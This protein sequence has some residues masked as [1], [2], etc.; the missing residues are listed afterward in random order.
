LLYE[1]KQLTECVQDKLS[2]LVWRGEIHRSLQQCPEEA[3]EKRESR[4]QSEMEDHCSR[5]PRMPRQPEAA[6]RGQAQEAEGN[7]DENWVVDEVVLY[8]GCAEEG[9]N[10]L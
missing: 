3:K 8:Q 1:V 6:Y 9:G 2:D 5:R 10:V 7:G 4:K